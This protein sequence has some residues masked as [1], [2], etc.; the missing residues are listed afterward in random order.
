MT[1]RRCPMCGRRPCGVGGCIHIAAPGKPYC[2]RHW[3]ETK[4]ALR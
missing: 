3:A 4:E 2:W 1:P